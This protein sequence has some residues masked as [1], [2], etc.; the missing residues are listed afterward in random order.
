MG[1]EAHELHKGCFSG[2]HRSFAVPFSSGEEH[3]LY[4]IAENIIIAHRIMTIPPEETLQFYK[5]L[6]FHPVGIPKNQVP[7]KADRSMSDAELVA[8]YSE[9]YVDVD[10]AEF[11]LKD[12]KERLHGLCN[13]VKEGE[14]Y[15]DVGCANGAHMEILRKRGV[16]GIGLDLSI[17]NIL[18]GRE[19]YPH[20]TFMHGFAEEIPFKDDYFDI[21]ILGDVIEHFRLPEVNIAESL[22]V[23]QK[24]L[25][26]CIPIKDEF[27][28]EH[29]CPFTYEKIVNLLRFYKLRLHFFNRAGEELDEEETFQESQEF[30]WLLVRATKT[31]QTAKVVK[32]VLGGVEKELE[33]KSPREI[34][35]KDQWLK[36]VAH[37]RHETESARLNLVSHLI[38]GNTVLKIGRGNGDDSICMAENGFKVICIDRSESRIRQAVEIA[39]KGIIQAKPNFM[40]MDA[41]RLSFK[42]NSFDT[43]VLPEVLACVKSSRKILLEA[44]RVARNGGRII[45]SVP[46]GLLTPCEGH[47]RVFFKDALSFELSQFAID[48]E[49][50][51]LPS[52][53]WLVCS[54]FVK[55]KWQVK[56]KEP[57]VD[58]MMATF[59]GRKYIR[60]A[61]KSVLNQTYDNWNLFVVN[62]GGEDIEDIII[63]FNDSRI[64]YIVTEHN[65]KA[66]ALNIGLNIS[67]AE[68]V[69]Y[70]DD[71]DILY[72]IHLEVLVRCALTNNIDFV[73]SDLYEVSVDENGADRY[74]EFVPRLDVTAGML[75]LRNYI[76]HNS[77][78]HRR[79]LLKRSACMMKTYVP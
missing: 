37:T 24:A 78:L 18:R 32:Q 79:R 70:L 31:D 52:K 60:K 11:L 10:V 12:R 51:E 20:L 59:N 3:A 25:A 76:N 14:F 41:T 71:D 4:K 34:L 64:K 68:F 47:L 42:D 16:N 53:K 46:N 27:T 13:M 50:H 49:W 57:T 36:D 66:H 69:T 30:P 63:E 73:Y 58:I 61:I 56:A 19:K 77:I 2:I 1:R 17:P 54:F 44:I 28:E 21:V 65:G 74:R 8:F 22:R 29:I 35:N 38:E 40:V 43:V 67:A 55:K 48:I 33:L 7:V 45:I 15:L 26:I 72:P 62:D 6:A 23:A 5:N 9:R 39:R 75:I